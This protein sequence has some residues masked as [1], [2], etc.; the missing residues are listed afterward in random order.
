MAHTYYYIIHATFKP[1]IRRVSGGLFRP[2]PPPYFGPYS[3]L[4]TL[5]DVLQKNSYSVLHVLHPK[6]WYSVLR[7]DFRRYSVIRDP[8]RH[9]LLGRTHYLCGVVSLH[10]R[11]LCPL[12]FSPKNPPKI[13]RKKCN[14]TLDSLPQLKHFLNKTPCVRGNC[15]LVGVLF[16]FCVVSGLLKSSQQ[17]FS[18][19]TKGDKSKPYQWY[20]KQSIY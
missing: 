1:N 11:K 3:V 12:I 19:V 7:T 9:P 14:P 13:F 2:P 6:I 16:L 5:K 20:L 8:P 10:I 18:V 4:Q 17:V 15:D